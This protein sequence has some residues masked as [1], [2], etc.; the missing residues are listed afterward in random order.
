MHQRNKGHSA[1]WTLRLL[2][3][4]RVGHLATCNLSLRPHVIPI[5][6]V[7]HNDAIYSAIDEKPKRR[8]PPGLRRIINIEANPNVCM[9]IDQYDENWRKLRFF[10]IHGKAKL[11]WLGEEHEQAINQLRRKY[12]QYRSMNLQSRP[13]I[14]II[15][16][17]TVSWRSDE[18]IETDKR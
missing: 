7:F 2:R 9:I 16:R 14:K 11:I 10:I 4:S 5:C 12:P 15:P 13:V 6:F 17:R 1:P 18:L 3:E 8:K